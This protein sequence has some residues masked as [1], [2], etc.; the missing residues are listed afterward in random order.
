MRLPFLVVLAIVLLS[1][2]VDAGVYTVRVF[3]L[4]GDEITNSSVDATV[5]LVVVKQ[6]GQKPIEVLDLGADQPVRRS[7]LTTTSG[8]FRFE[9]PSDSAT[10]QFDPNDKRVEFHFSRS[11]AE[12][13]RSAVEPVQFAVTA[14]V[15]EILGNSTIEQSM[16][17]VVPRVEVK[18][19]YK[20]VPKC[21]PESPNCLSTPCDW[22][23][24]LHPCRRCNRVDRRRMQVI[25][26]ICIS[27]DVPRDE[28]YNQGCCLMTEDTRGS[29]IAARVALA[30]EDQVPTCSYES[31][32]L[33]SQPSNVDISAR[34]LWFDST[35]TKTA[36]ASFLYA[37]DSRA[38]FL[39]DAGRQVSTLISNLSAESQ[40]SVRSL[41]D[42]RSPIVQMADSGLQSRF[43][44]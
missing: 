44:Y 19:R 3:D 43:A 38:Y 11:P 26:P 33:S 21:G 29:T 15:S 18:S 6:I 42:K 41:T 10:I 39:S 17:V 35:G 25:R 8:V 7:S 30:C 31:S 2:G 13:G 37:T 20:E 40:Q 16:E 1:A 5:T 22:G 28:S 9:I 4:T 36:R 12:F 34:Q 27:Q 32:Q 24:R 14:I 23:S